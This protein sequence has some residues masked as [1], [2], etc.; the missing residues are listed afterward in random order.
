MGKITEARLALLETQIKHAVVKHIGTKA[1][2]YPSYDEGTYSVFVPGA[3]REHNLVK[4]E[5]EKEA[6]EKV[7]VCLEK[8]I[9]V[10]SE[11]DTNDVSVSP[12]NLKVQTKGKV[13]LKE[14]N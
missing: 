8:K 5:N 12:D 7:R 10:M 9:E 11:S 4:A 3:I 6:V 1:N 14:E 13:T 2:D